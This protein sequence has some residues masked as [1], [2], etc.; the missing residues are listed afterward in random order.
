MASIKIVYVVETCFSQRDNKRFFIDE[1][2]SLGF[3]VLVLDLVKIFHSKLY[4][5]LEPYAQKRPEGVIEVADLFDF[6]KVVNTFCPDFCFN[7]V[8]SGLKNYSARLKLKYFLKRKT[9]VIDY[10]VINLPYGLN[11]RNFKDSFREA[12]KLVAFLPFNFLKP[13]FS[14]V[15][16]HETF[17]ISQGNP[18]IIHEFDYDLYLDAFNTT[19]PYAGDPYILFLDEDCV[20]HS[21]FIYRNIKNPCS[22]DF[23]FKEVN[24]ALYELGKNLNLKPLIQLHPRAQVQQSSEFYEASIS[25]KLTAEA[26]RDATLVVAH[27]STAIQI[28]VLF[29]RPILLLETSEYKMLKDPYQLLLNFEQ[30]L[31]CQVITPDTASLIKKVPAVNQNA[32]EVYERKYIKMPGSQRKAGYEI[33]SE[34]LIDVLKKSRK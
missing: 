22:V 14:F 8:M 32:Y 25:N 17:K 13:H 18:L 19:A 12:L 4:D 26:I 15:T 28:A 29:K 5:R 6:Y 16:N 30:I 11:R 20:F 10:N 3:E 23:Y 24:C 2:R 1:L 33:F 7:F 34:F 31:H 21:D 27:A 9:I